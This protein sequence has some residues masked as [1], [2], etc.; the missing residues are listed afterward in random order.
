MVLNLTWPTNRK[1]YVIYRTTPFSMTLNDPL[2]SFSRSYRHSDIEILIWTLAP[3]TTMSFRMILSDLAKYSMTRSAT[4][5]LLVNNM[6]DS[7]TLKCGRWLWEHA[8]EF[9]Q[10]SAILDGILFIWF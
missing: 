3:Y 8:I 2:P 4:A 5:E 7:F 9:G 1:S 6:A 10:T